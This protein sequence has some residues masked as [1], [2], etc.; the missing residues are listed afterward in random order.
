MKICIYHFVGML[1]PFL[2][3]GVN[4]KKIF[5]FCS[6]IHFCFVKNKK[7]FIYHGVGHKG[8]SHLLQFPLFNCRAHLCSGIEINLQIMF[9]V[10]NTNTR[11]NF[12]SYLHFE[13]NETNKQK[14]E[15]NLSCCHTDC[16][17]WSIKECWVNILHEKKKIYLFV[18]CKIVNHTM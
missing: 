15:I 17:V 13:I 2:H 11:I 4:K 9:S 14:H 16:S 7:R 5:F 6:T 18:T 8:R 12:R 3:R 10:L 1:I